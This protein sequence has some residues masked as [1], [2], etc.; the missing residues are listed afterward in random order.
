MATDEEGRRLPIA[1]EALIWLGELWREWN[2]LEAATRLLTEGIEL[3]QQWSEMAA[4]DAYAPLARVRRAQG[5]MDGARQAIE[6]AR[7]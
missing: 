7:Q 1:S 6:A 3:A 5:D 2:D 4:F